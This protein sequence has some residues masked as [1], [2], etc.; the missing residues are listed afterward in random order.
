[1]SQNQGIFAGVWGWGGYTGGAVS[2]FPWGWCRRVPFSSWEA[3]SLPRERGGGAARGMCSALPTDSSDPAAL[4]VLP[5][6][7]GH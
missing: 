5:R 4:G 3:G 2:L 7:G 6:L 1:M